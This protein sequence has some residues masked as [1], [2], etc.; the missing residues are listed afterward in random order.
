MIYV[1]SDIHGN[2]DALRVF[3]KNTKINATD[4]IYALGDYV[5]YY[6]NPNKCLNLLRKKKVECIK[7]N[8]DI[9]LLNIKNKPNLI[10]KYVKKYGYAY[11]EAMNKLTNENLI[12]IK[13]MKTKKIVKFKNCTALLS[14]GSPWQ[15]DFYIYPDV[16]KN[17][18]NR[19]KKYKQDIFF[20]GHTHR[21]CK[22]KISNKKIYNPGSIGQPR[23]GIKGSNWLTFDP[24][25]KKVTFYNKKYATTILKKSVKKK[26]PN[27]FK[28][29]TK[30]L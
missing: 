10:N 30:Y 14:H 3:F 1:I 15:N 11:K 9:N 16:K 2:I 12:F 19:F 5:G 29:L 18:L 25:T 26:D 20:V 28:E 17:I 8:H 22:L 24:L 23:D 6:Y 13:K 27:K 4:K 21:A 7:G